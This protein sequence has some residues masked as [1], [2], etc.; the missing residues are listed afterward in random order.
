MT[1]LLRDSFGDVNHKLDYMV[2]NKQHGQLVQIDRSNQP[3]PV[4]IEIDNES[5]FDSDGDNTAQA[6][7]TSE[8]FLES[9]HVVNSNTAE[10]YLQLFDRAA[11]SVTVGTTAPKQSYLIPSGD[12]VSSAGFDR[13]FNPPLHFNT[14]ISYACTT[15]ATGSTD[16]TTGLTV[17]L[18][19]HRP[20]LHSQVPGT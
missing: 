18:I 13:V 20:K 5:V 15:T 9:I 1:N 2:G 17:N 14:A 12:G 3:I 6:G 7:S 10:V 16:P 19:Y 4:F 11:G 8:S